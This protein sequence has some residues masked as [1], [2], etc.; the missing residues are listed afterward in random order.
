MGSAIPERISAAVPP[1]TTLAAAGLASASA[2]IG[3]GWRLLGALLMTLALGTLYAWSVFVAPLEA[4]FGWKRAQTSAVFTIAVLMFASSFILAGRLQDKFGPFW[5]A[6]TGSV[7]VSAGFLLCTFTYSLPYLFFCYG[8]LGGIGNSFGYSTVV[9]VIAKWFPD[10]RGLAVGLALAGYGGG[11]A[12]FGPIA[13]LWMIP[14][15]GW[16]A[17]FAAFGLIL[18]VMTM[19]GAFLLRNPPQGYT[20]KGWTPSTRRHE[21]SAHEFTPGEVLR[22]PSFYLMW[23]GFGFGSTAGLMVISQLVPFATSQG[24][25]GAALATLGLVVGALG[26]VS[27]RILSGWISDA[28]GRLNTLRVILVIATA[29]MPI[30]Y[31]VGA[32]VA[33]LYVMVF[34]VYFCYGAQGAVNPTTVADFWGMRNAGV[35]YSLLF[36]AWGVAGTIGPTI[37]GVFYDR[38]RNYEAAFYAASLLAGVALACELMARRPRAPSNAAS[39]PPGSRR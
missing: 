17:T 30:L 28:L 38:Y 25:P 37:G 19:T 27:G 35:N 36:T 9:P 13:N 16:R 29:A 11:S 12:V 34:V 3:R 4:E 26:N 1:A 20:P 24:I 18:L 10:K 2:S 32:N 23:C 8:V 22:T 39:A 31:R 7:L 14:H 15:L 5:V 21:Q 6:V 33:A